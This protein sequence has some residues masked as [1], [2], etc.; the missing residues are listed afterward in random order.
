MACERVADV[1]QAN[2]RGAALDPQRQDAVGESMAADEGSGEVAEGAGAAEV[3][4]RHGAALGEGGAVAGVALE[5]LAAAVEAQGEAGGDVGGERGDDEERLEGEVLVV[6]PGE[7]EVGV[8]GRD[9]A[10][11]EGYQGG[12]GDVGGGEDGEGVGR[13]F[14]DAGYWRWVS[15]SSQR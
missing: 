2:S 6:G 11:G 13:V 8:A 5:G 3:R 10:G 15:K 1:L 4:P 12:V 7:E 14:L 9:G